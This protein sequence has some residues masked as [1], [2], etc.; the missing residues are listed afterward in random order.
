[1]KSP[2]FESLKAFGERIDALNLR[3]R[4]LVFAG[5]LG[6]LLVLATN[7][8]FPSL[9]AEQKRLESELK[10]KREQT[11]ALYAQIEGMAKTAQRDT[12]AETRARIAELKTKLRAIEG[13]AAPGAQQLVTPREMVR[14]V[15]EVLARNQALRLVRLENLPATAMVQTAAAATPGAV[16][17]LDAI[18][19]QIY[20]HGLRI[21]VRGSYRDIARYVQVL[22]SL[23]WRVFWGEMQLET[24]R[25][26]VSELTLVVYTLSPNPEWIGT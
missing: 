23:P 7:F 4:A 8:L 6:V 17:S 21:K 25:Y 22:E 9:Q 11:R 16:A 15:R 24:Q 1:M 20:R 5:V 18:G 14:L 12:E 13:P 10:V 2:A 3:E 19:G 26:P